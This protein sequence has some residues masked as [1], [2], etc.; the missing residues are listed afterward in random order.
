V[1]TLHPEKA[2]N[3]QIKESRKLA[4]QLFTAGAI[5]WAI[6]KF[7]PFKA[8]GAD[9]IFPAL[10]Q[11]GL[12]VL[13]PKLQELF[14]ASFTLGY[15][16]SEWRR[17]RVVFIPKAGRRPAEEARSYRPICL[18]S[19]LLKTMEKIVDCHMRGTTLREKPLHPRQCAYQPGKSTID[20]LHGLTTSIEA[21]L[22]EKEIG[23]GIFIDIEGAFDNATF[24]SVKKE[25][26]N[27]GVD[28]PIIRWLKAILTNRLISAEVNGVSST[29]M[30]VKVC[31]QG[32]VLSPLLWMFVADSLLK[33]VSEKDTS[34]MD[35]QTTSL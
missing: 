32:G 6:R 15:L 24:E 33:K 34:H 5:E 21:A 12:S 9:G 7:Q 13:L 1:S 20:A 25:A 4:R 27:K 28:D 8:P 35:T 22:R 31:P 17:S 14:R 26:I 2:T 18:T 29:V 3:A 16:P 11:R 23:L 10:L 30:A 19:F